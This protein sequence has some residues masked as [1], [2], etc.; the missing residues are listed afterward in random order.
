MPTVR[1]PLSFA[2]GATAHAGGD[3]HQ[4]GTLKSLLKVSPGFLGR[5]LADAGIATGTKATGQRLSKLNPV[6]CCR[7]QEGLGIGIEN[8]IGDPLEIALNHSIHS[9]AATTANADDFNAGG[10]TRKNP[11]ALGAGG[12]MC[13][14]H[15]HR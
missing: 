12:L 8:P 9:I 14:H 4:I 11:G 3:E 10:L 7:L 1:A 15:L 5:L 2:T 6:V 13:A